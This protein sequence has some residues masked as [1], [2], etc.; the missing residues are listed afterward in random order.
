MFQV[1]GGLFVINQMVDR[2][3]RAADGARVAMLNRNR[4]ELHR[5]GIEGKQ[6]VGQQFADTGEILQSLS[7]LNGAQHTCDSTQYASLRTGGNGS[8][9]RRF[10]EHTTIAGRAGQMGKRLAVEAQDASM[11]ERLA[12]HHTSVVD[13]KLHREVVGTI[14][15]EVVLL[16]DIERV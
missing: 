14:D 5:L 3:V 4:A 11:R 9:G 8:Y 10:L 1:A 13:E 12:R 16:D 15:D 6:T 7:G 2:G